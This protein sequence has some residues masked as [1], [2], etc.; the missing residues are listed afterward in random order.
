MALRP[1]PE[2]SCPSRRGRPAEAGT[3]R[4]RGLPISSSASGSG[5]ARPVEDPAAHPRS[6]RGATRARPRAVAV[7]QGVAEERADGLGGWQTPWVEV[8]AHQASIGA[9][10]ARC[11]TGSRAPTPARSCPC[12]TGDQAVPGLLVGD[13]AEDRVVGEQR[14]A[15]EVHLGDQP[16]GERRAE[17]REVDVR[18]PPGVVV[19]AP[20]VG[21]RLDGDEPVAAVVVGEAAAGAGEVGVERRGVL[22]AQVGVAARRRWPARPRPARRAPGG[23]RVSST[24]PVTMIRSPSGSPR[25]AWSGR[26][27]AGRA[28]C[29][30]DRADSS[31]ASGPE[32]RARAAVRAPAARCCVG[33]GEVGRMGMRLLRRGVVFRAGRSIGARSPSRISSRGDARRGLDEDQAVR[34]DV[35]DAEVGDDPVR[36]TPAPVSGSVHSLTIL[37]LP[38][39]AVCSITTITRRAPCTR[40]IAPP[41]PLIILPG[42]AQ[43]ARSPR[44]ETCIAPSTATSTWPPRIM[45]KDSEESK[46][47]APGSDGHG[48]LARVDQ[49]RVDLV[50]GRVGPD[51]EHAVLGVQ[52]HVDAVRQVAGDQRRQPDAEVD[53]GAVGQLGAARAAISSLVQLIG[54]PLR[55]VADRPL[56]DGLVGGLLGRQLHDALHEDARAG[57]RAS[58]SISPGSTSSLDLGDGDPAGHRGQRVE[59]AGGLVEDQVAVP[60]AE[61]RADEREVGGDALLQH[62]LPAA[63]LPDLLGRRGDRDRAVRARTATGGRPRRPSCRRRRGCRTRGC[64]RRPRAAARRAC[65]A[66]SARPRSPRRRRDERHPVDRRRP[67]HLRRFHPRAAPA[68]DGLRGRARAGGAD[69]AHRHPDGRGRLAARARRPARSVAGARRRRVGDRA[70]GRAADRPDRPAHRGDPRHRAHRR[71]DRAAAPHHARQHV[72]QRQPVHGKQDA[73]PLFVYRLVRFPQTASDPSGVDR[74]ARAAR[75]S[76][77]SCSSSPGSSG[78]ADP[79]TSDGSSASDSRERASHDLIRHDRSDGH[80]RQPTPS[81]NDSPPASR[82]ATSAPGSATTRCSSASRSR[83]AP[84]QVTA[85]IGPS[86]CGKSTFLRILNRMH[87]LVPSAS[88]AGTV[89][90]DGV[91]IYRSE[92]RVTD[93]RRRIGMV[94]QKPNPF[95]AMTRRRERRRGTQA[96]PVSAPTARHATRSSRTACAAPASG[97]R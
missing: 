79:A 48:L 65:P 93:I 60:V 24:R 80:Q 15:G 2:K 84:N 11:P 83:C 91:D 42:T 44:A 86:G 94:F 95:P 72:I 36:R 53:V 14:V 82:R 45:P 55:R 69:A 39:L 20:R 10:R 89:A 41:I 17:H 64:R 7:R 96:R 68:A 51:A 37:G 34:G 19:V 61:R 88:L 77:S 9:R 33:R 18:G 97:T 38:S 52:H 90:L 57:A 59:V 58:G 66:A 43:L 12:R 30:E 13:R 1:N 35:E 28:R 54:R 40:S 76:C 87:E 49:V 50:L 71:R 8:G 81:P 29:A 27:R 6:R 3:R 74:R 67:V 92:L 4:R 16:L 25:A 22:V 5:V 70:A 78:D 21:A 32:L 75:C 73:L 85:L 63:E 26:G 23:R 56:L 46:N 62:V 47:A 31:I